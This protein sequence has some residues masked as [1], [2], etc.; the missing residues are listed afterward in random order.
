M[1]CPTCGDPMK[2]I[3]AGVSK[4]TGRAYRSFEICEKPSCKAVKEQ[5]KY[6]VPPS[7]QNVPQ[8][9][10]TTSQAILDD[11]QIKVDGLNQ[12]IANMRTAFQ[13]HE[14]RIKTLEMLAIDLKGKPAFDLHTAP[15]VHVSHPDIPIINPTSSDKVSIEFPE[16]FLK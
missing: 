11:L 3:P 13:N 7:A 5:S 6:N 1:Q 9:N 14:N 16:G 10:F 2:V 8:S 4:K 12:V 15:S